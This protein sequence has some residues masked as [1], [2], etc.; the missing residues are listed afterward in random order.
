MA[1]VNGQWVPDS[2]L[3]IGYGQPIKA[4]GVYNPNTQ[5]QQGVVTD[6]NAV[7][8]ADTANS[9]APVTTNSGGLAEQGWGDKF[10]SW[11]TPQGTAGTSVGGNIMSGIGAGVGALSGLAGMYYAG[12]N[13]ELQ[14]DNQ[15]YLQNREAQSDARKKQFA[16]NA[17]NSATY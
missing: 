3:G 2:P 10:A 13:Y 1:I 8:V 15:K 16:A 7:Q 12:K 17:G 11:F 14:K 9:V 5:F 6:A 4:N